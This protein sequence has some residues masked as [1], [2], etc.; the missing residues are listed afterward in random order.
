M[1]QSP[2][3]PSSEQLRPFSAEL[4]LIAAI[5][6]VLVTPFFTSRSN[7]PTA[8]VALVGLIAALVG[9]I[10][11]APAACNAG[12]AFGGMLVSD[13]FAVLWKAILLLFVTGVVV[14]GLCTV[15]PAM[16]EGD[17]PEFYAL[18]L[19]ATLGMSL[20]GSA[21]NLLMVFMA[22]ELASL[23]SYVLAGFRKT[24]RGG[25]EASL[26]YVLFGAASSAMMVYGLSMLYGLFGTLDIEPI[27][28]QIGQT[29]ATIPL[30]LG[31]A[32]LLI[33]L[34]FKISA[35]PLH[36]WC[37]D[38]FE[39][40]AI[41]VTT[42]LSV[43][44]KGAG[45]VLL[46]RLVMSF[47][48]GVGFAGD[49]VI[50]LA[51][52]IGV[53]GAVTATVGNT[54]AFVQ[55]NI[56]RLLAYSSIAHAGYMLCAVALLVRPAGA[57]AAA[58]SQ[59]VAQALL[60]YLAVYLFMNLG[61]FTVAGLIYRATGS[62]N[63]N[64]Y[65]GMSRRNPVLAVCMAV[66]LLSLVGLPPLAGFG[67]KLWVMKVLAEGG[68]WWWALVGVIG[69]NTIASL[70]YYARVLRV[71]FLVESESPPVRVGTVGSALAMACAA[72]LFLMFVGFYPMLQLTGRYAAM[73]LPR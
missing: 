59:A 71:M 55:N 11:A 35:V 63:I 56:K 43:A 7:R 26:K 18:L 31:L 34:G 61:A 62:E 58:S 38:V 25:S 6:A 45:L 44:S 30:I 21:N 23:P 5:V 51:G 53:M 16:R 48:A 20:M 36:F 54:A 2:F 50:A 52:V 40:A 19:S 22:V 13:S 24:D 49:V 72:V 46:L 73:A 42:F 28:R 4:W 47:A 39:G 14:M 57:D 32:G 27:A 12:S 66:C 67:A 70:Y 60:L 9:L 15:G 33:G 69:V 37:P 10:L 65:A 3:I 17:G 1:G 68:G 29:G 41:D 8:V 64:D